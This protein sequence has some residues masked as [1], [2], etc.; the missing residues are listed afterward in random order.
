MSL[1]IGTIVAVVS[2]TS[3]LAW[4]VPSG[5]HS[6]A[7]GLS[8]F[9]NNCGASTGVW[10]TDGD[11]VTTTKWNQLVCLTYQT[12][13]V[14]YDWGRNQTPFITVQGGS[15]GANTGSYVS[16]VQLA[17]AGG[18][19]SIGFYNSASAFALTSTQNSLGSIRYTNGVGEGLHMTSNNGP[20]YI[21]TVNNTSANSHANDETN[22]N[23]QFPLGWVSIN[24]MDTTEFDPLC[25]YRVTTNHLHTIYMTAVSGGYIRSF[26]DANHDDHLGSPGRVGVPKEN[27]TQLQNPIEV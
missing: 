13:N 19:G 23:K 18:G 17:A 1:G 27:K 3:A 7:S 10:A 21:D 12:L 26:L 8:T 15:I 14:L 22:G 9:F 24:L 16:G 20:V 25:M 5:L 11:V 4:S 6:N 2:V